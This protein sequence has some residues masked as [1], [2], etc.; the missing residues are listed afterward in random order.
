[1]MRGHFNEM[2]TEGVFMGKDCKGLDGKTL[3]TILWKME[4]WK[5]ITS[6]AVAVCWNAMVYCDFYIRNKF[7]GL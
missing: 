3:A 6:A 1:M 2:D 5:T 7:Q 4:I